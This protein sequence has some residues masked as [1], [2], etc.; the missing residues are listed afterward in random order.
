VCLP[1]FSEA[2]VFGDAQRVQTPASSL[3]SK[4]S[5]PTPPEPLKEN[6][7]LWARVSLVFGAGIALTVYVTVLVA[8]LPALSLA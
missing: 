2:Y 6:V 4:C 1:R 7:A 8:A 3:H 5:A